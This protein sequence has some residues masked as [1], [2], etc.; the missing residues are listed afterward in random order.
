MTLRDM[1]PDELE[2]VEAETVHPRDE[3][4]GGRESQPETVRRSPSPHDAERG[5]G[6]GGVD[7]DADGLPDG[8]VERRV[9]S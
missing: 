2:P 7:R 3:A 5:D 1:I 8:A 6:E 4:V 9:P